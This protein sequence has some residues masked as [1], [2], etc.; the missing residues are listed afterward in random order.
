M[1]RPTK[2]TP[3]VQKRVCDA[4]RTGNTRKASAAYAGISETTFATYLD[5]YGDFR[6]AIREAETAAEVKH[7]ANI[8]KA[9]EKDWRASMEWLARRRSAD[10]AKRDNIDLTSGGKPFAAIIERVNT[11]PPPADG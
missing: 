9:G 1:A 4:L 7:V 3:D 8:Y 2:L 6:D 5:R 11:A 10:W